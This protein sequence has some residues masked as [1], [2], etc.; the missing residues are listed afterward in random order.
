MIVNIILSFD[1]EEMTKAADDGTIY[2]L[3]DVQKLAKEI[4]DEWA[5]FYYGYQGWRVEVENETKE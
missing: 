4:N 3:P 2:K 5:G 1:L